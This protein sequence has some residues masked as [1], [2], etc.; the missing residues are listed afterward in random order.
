MSSQYFIPGGECLCLVLWTWKKIHLPWNPEFN[1]IA[2]WQLSSLLKELFKQC[3]KTAPCVKGPLKEWEHYLIQWLSEALFY[4]KFLSLEIMY[5]ENG[6]W[7]IHLIFE[8]VSRETQSYTTLMPCNGTCKA[9]S[10]FLSHSL[11]L[12]IYQW[13]LEIIQFYCFSKLRIIPE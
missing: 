12:S 8:N 13:I 5:I 6:S 9:G 11:F 10:C 1:K 7:N 3:H 2:N 4:F